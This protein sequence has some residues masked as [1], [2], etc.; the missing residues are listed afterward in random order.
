MNKNLD[1][2]LINPGTR[3]A[4]YGQIGSLHCIA[5][6]L[7]IGMIAAYVRAMGYSVE[8]LDAQAEN[9]SPAQVGDIVAEKTPILAG[10]SA[11][12]PQMT[13]ATE[14]IHS[15]KDEAPQVKTIIGGHHSASLPERTLRETGVDFVCNTEGYIPVNELLEKLKQQP[16]SDGSSINGLCYLENGKVAINPPPPL[17]RNLDE[18]PFVA[19]DLLPMEKYRAHNWHCLGKE[20]RSP[21]AVVFTSLGCPFNCSYCSVNAVYGGNVYR[22]RS[23]KNF[24]A[25]I[26]LLVQQYDVKHMEIVDDTFTINKKR[27]HEI[28]DLLI[29]RDYGLNLWAYAR[30]DTV[31]GDLLN[32]MKKAGINWVAYGFES[33]SEIVRHGVRKEQRHIWD[34]VDITYD[35]GICIMSNFI[36]GLPEDNYETMQMTLDLAKEINGEY[37]NFW[38]AMAYPG[39]ELYEMAVKNGWNLP[40]V[41]HGYSQYAYET[42]P[43]STRFLSGREVLNFR[44]GAFNEYFSNPAYLQKIEKQFGTDAVKSI[45]N[46]LKK[47]LV[48]KYA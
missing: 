3:T 32:K 48:R 29:E 19:W 22:T 21:Y 42:L 35:A 26:D 14:I 1:L 36:F 28:C 33:G 40:D 2:L 34:A 15:I 38:C 45:R 44:D 37:A 31:D 10:V 16:E 39:S 47:K 7:G 9:L 5:P 43:L 6:P 41:W 13:A 18:L 20:T 46:M 23:A 11:F 4:I 30:T 25:E 24:L 8:I 17:T 12:T 27:V